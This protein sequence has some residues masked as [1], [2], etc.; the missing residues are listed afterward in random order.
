[1]RQQAPL[2][3]FTPIIGLEIHCQIKTKTKMFCSC[4][5]NPNEKKPNYNVCPICLGHPGT[6]PTANIK[7]IEKTIKLGTALN[8][9]IAIMAKFDRKNYFYPDLPKG[10]Q[11]SQH[12]M[13]F[14]KQ[15]M[16]KIRTDNKDKYIRINR[17]HLEEDTGK[18]IHKK[19]NSLID[20]NRAGIPLLELVTEPDIRSE[21]QA[22]KF[23]EELQLIF[24]YLDISEANMEK[25]EMRIEANISL[26]PIKEVCFPINNKDN[27]KNI[28]FNKLGTKIEIKNLN[29]FKALE[30]AIF[31]EIKRQTQ[32]LKAKQK[33]IQET[34]GWNEKQKITFSQRVKETAKDYRYFP[35]PDLPIFF[36]ESSIKNKAISPQYDIEC[37]QNTNKSLAEHLKNISQK[38]RPF[39]VL[40]IESFIPVLPQAKKTILITKHSISEKNAQILIEK[41]KIGIFFE[42]VLKELNIK[43]K[44]IP[45]KLKQIVVNYLIND[46]QNLQEKDNEDILISPKNFAEF[47]ILIYNNT[48]SSK[49][50][51]IVLN[52]LFKTN[53]KPLTI[54]KEKQLSLITDQKKIE[55]IIKKIIQDNPEIVQKY[56][57][58]QIETIQFLIGQ[59]IKQSNNRIDP[60]LIKK[61]L[62]KILK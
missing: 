32:I 20:F 5:N 49:S 34:R 58:G 51:K 53:K 57:Q 19:N 6:L 50:A 45:P 37:L 16:L 1:M 38:I 9:K 8:S 17:I 46:L 3:R 26:I 21:K 33:I 40:K 23:A 36:I 60:I 44:I 29:S 30:E 11:I 2:M 22:R 13:P 56:Q 35:E 62:I 48:L 42:K 7:A 39:N 28:N 10:Y 31:Y 18:I 61:F 43:F 24:R 4:L 12:D 14:C 15:G 54:I 41:N 52:S 27:N 55:T 59:T 47:S 25:G